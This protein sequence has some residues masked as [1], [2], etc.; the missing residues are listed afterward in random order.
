MVNTGVCS[1]LPFSQKV[2]KTTDFCLNDDG[3]CDDFG[4]VFDQ[5]GP[6][7]GPFGIHPMAR[8]QG[9]PSLPE[10]GRIFFTNVNGMQLQS[11]EAAF[12]HLSKI[13][14][15]AVIVIRLSTARVSFASAVR[16]KN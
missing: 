7:W 14:R 16:K 3:K 6:N 13:E 11:A 15:K 10:W 4:V 8:N 12:R 5:N 1:R 9:I 2:N